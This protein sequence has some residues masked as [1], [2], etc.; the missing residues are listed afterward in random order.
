[1]ITNRWGRIYILQNKRLCTMLES[2]TTIAPVSREITEKVINLAKK[3]GADW[4][5]DFI[6]MNGNNYYVDIIN[7]RVFYLVD[8]NC[9]K[10]AESDDK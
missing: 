10:I 1:M 4:D 2:N 3:L 7:H 5:G 6:S 8:T 9:R